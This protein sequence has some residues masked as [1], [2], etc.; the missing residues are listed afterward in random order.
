M[1]E[2]EGAARDCIDVEQTRCPTMIPQYA[3]VSIEK[4][5]QDLTQ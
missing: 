2:A 1:L 4:I 5:R 3:D